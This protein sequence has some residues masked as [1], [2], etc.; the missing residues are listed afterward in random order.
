LV[1]RHYGQARQ[2]RRFKHCSESAVRASL[3]AN[4]SDQA[5]ATRNKINAG[6]VFM[7]FNNYDE[8]Q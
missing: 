5:Q 6:L 1:G 3:L 4:G 8:C 2:Q 7:P